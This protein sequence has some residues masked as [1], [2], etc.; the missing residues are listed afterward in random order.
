MKWSLKHGD[1]LDEPADVLVCSA[2]VF[3][4]L[5]GGVGGAFLLRYGGQMQEELHRYLAQRQVRSVRPG[6]VVA[7]PP[8]GSPYKAVLHA[9]AIDAFYDSSP[10]RVHEALRVSLRAAAGLE[11]R[12]VALAALATGYGRLSMS[13][14]AE[15]LCSLI[16]EHFPPIE[17]VALCLRNR[18][19]VE[20]LAGLGPALALIRSHEQSG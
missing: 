8:C 13:A 11:A 5:S 17:E 3:L 4:N 15:G 18:A 9:V 2:N 1:V 14:F 19:D 6:E 7:M 16:G 12:K 10:E 20:E